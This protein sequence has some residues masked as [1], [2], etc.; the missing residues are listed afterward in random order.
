M[1]HPFKECLLSTCCVADARSTAVS[2]RDRIYAFKGLVFRWKITGRQEPTIL[3]IEFYDKEVVGAMG[4]PRSRGFLEEE[5][6][7]KGK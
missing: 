7:V 6:R 2:S 3:G 1:T 5:M 4:I